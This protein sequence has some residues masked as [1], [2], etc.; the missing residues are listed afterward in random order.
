V[1]PETWLPKNG[2]YM[3]ATMKYAV[4]DLF[5]LAWAQQ[6]VE[7]FRDKRP[8][9]NQTGAK[10]Q[11]AERCL[12]IEGIETMSLRQAVERMQQ[13]IRQELERNQ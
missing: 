6:R 12:K 7:Y 10:P 8:D 4:E 11:A 2:G 1:R 13:E 3:L 9:I 5:R